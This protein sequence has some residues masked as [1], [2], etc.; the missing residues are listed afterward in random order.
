M[1]IRSNV[2]LEVGKITNV[3]GLLTGPDG[4]PRRQPFVALEEVTEQDWLDFLHEQNLYMETPT[5]KQDR[6]YRISVD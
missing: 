4:I 1:I 3:G 6:F 5:L 2:P